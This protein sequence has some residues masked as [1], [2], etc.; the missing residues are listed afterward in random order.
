MKKLNVGLVGFGYWGPNYARLLINNDKTSLVK[1]C[2]TNKKVLDEVTQK[3]G[4]NTTDNL[5]DLLKDPQVEAIIISTPT[6]THYNL[7]KKSLQAK[8]HVLVEKPLTTTVA[9][10]DQLIKLAQKQK[11][12][13]MVGHTFI[14]NNY[15][16]TLNNLVKTEQLGD[17]R[18]IT[19]NRTNLGPIRQDVNV[20]WDLAPHDISMILE[21]VG[22]LPVEVFATGADYIKDGNIDVAFVDLKFPGNVLANISLSWLSPIKIRQMTIVGSKKMAVFD[23][24]K[25]ED[26]LILYNKGVTIPPRGSTYSE[27][28]NFGIYQGIEEIVHL[29]AQEPLATQLDYFISAILNEKSTKSDGEKGKQVVQ[30][31]EACQK[32]ISRKKPILL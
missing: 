16:E 2:D 17:M 12:Q 9:Q 5:N 29:P 3:L 7:V 30:V 11:L 18:F 8:K 21:L 27:F 15:F 14:Y 13:L 31:L 25:L 24:T 26:K 6:S 20:L 4:I 23:D 22:K 1:I 10:S 28:M 32:S 19:S